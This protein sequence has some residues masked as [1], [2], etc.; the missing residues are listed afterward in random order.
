LRK[1]DL[2]VAFVVGTTFEYRR[3]YLDVML[4]AAKHICISF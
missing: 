3:L 2:R 4:S 1:G